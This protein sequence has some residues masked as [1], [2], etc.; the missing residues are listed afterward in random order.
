[1][2]NNLPDEDPKL[3]KFLRQHRS[4]APSVPPELED[5]LFSQIDLLSIEKRSSF[6]NTW[7]RYIIGGITII[8]TGVVGVTIH[9]FMNPPELSIAEL[10]QLNLYLEDR[11]LGLVDRPEIGAGDE[12]IM[13]LDTDLF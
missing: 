4:I 10:N 11:I 13:D 6:L 3:T 9:Q 8:A 7:R 5:R 2:M 12:N 1:M